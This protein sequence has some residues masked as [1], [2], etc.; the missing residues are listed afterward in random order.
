MKKSFDNFWQNVPHCELS[1]ESKKFIC[2]NLVESN[3]LLKNWLSYVPRRKVRHFRNQILDG[4]LTSIIEL[5]PETMRLSFFD[6]CVKIRSIRKEK[7]Q[8]LNG[9]TI[10]ETV[11]A[12]YSKLV[13]KR[14]YDFN[15]KLSRKFDLV[16]DMYQESYIKIIDA[17]Y[18]YTDENVCFSTFLCTIVQNHLYQ[19][20]DENNLVKIPYSERKLLKAYKNHQKEN[21]VRKNEVVNFEQYLEESSIDKKQASRL[22]KIIVSMKES[23][24]INGIDEEV[25]LDIPDKSTCEFITSTSVSDKLKINEKVKNSIANADLTD[26]EKMALEYALSVEMKYGWQTELSVQMNVT[27]MR[28]SQIV[29]SAFG[30]VREFILANDQDA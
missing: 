11:V 4:N 7:I 15:K 6:D 3:K 5:I 12:G 28:V 2:S 8:S 29:K 23:K 25:N 22:Q 17:I 21:F 18:S 26:K 13:L 20:L 14:I 19:I 30:K 24:R 9:R 27:K 1:D 16:F 10:E